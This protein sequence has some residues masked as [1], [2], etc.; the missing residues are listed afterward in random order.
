MDCPFSKLLISMCPHDSHH[1][2][3]RLQEVRVGGLRA[4]PGKC[5]TVFV[6]FLFLKKREILSSSLSRQGR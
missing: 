4:H 5:L 2:L 3:P 6:L 1:L